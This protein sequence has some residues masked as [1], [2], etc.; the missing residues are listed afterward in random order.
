[1]LYARYASLLCRPQDIAD[2]GRYRKWCFIGK[3]NLEHA[4]ALYQKTYPGGKDDVFSVKWRPYYLNNNALP[5]SVEKSEFAKTKLAG[6][7]DEKVA[8]IRKRVDQVGLSVGIVFKS[9]GK[10]GSTRDAHRLIHLSQMKAPG[11]QDAI[12]ETLFQAYHEQEKD[13]SSF[14]VLCEIATEAGLEASEVREWLESDNAGNV[15]DE[16]A[17]KNKDVVPS[18]VPW[19]IIQKEHQVDGAQE[20]QDFFEAFFKVK[21]VNG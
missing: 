5:E 4:I 14:E 21:E 10:I 20:S 17:R 3:R 9:G 2:S 6:M 8:A 15:V 7:S 19:F 16:A 1:M 18:G 11:V 13:I 12:V